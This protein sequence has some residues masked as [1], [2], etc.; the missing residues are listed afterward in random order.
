LLSSVLYVLFGKTSTGLLQYW[1]SIIWLLKFWVK[2]SDYLLKE[3][4][5]EES[6]QCALCPKCDKVQRTKNIHER[7]FSILKT[8]ERNYGHGIKDPVVRCPIHGIS[9]LSNLKC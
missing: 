8:K 2:E 7:D 6:C 3:D 4:K 9:K 1:H 5:I